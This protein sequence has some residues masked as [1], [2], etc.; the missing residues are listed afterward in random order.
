ME[1]L[2]ETEAIGRVVAA[3]VAGGLLGWERERLQKAAGLRTHALVCEGAALFMVASILLGD[4]VRAAG[5]IGYDPSRI[6]STIVQ[7][8]GFLAAGVIF[9]A[10]GRVRGLTSAATIWVTAAIGLV[11]GAGLYVV[12]TAGVGLTLFTLAGLR[13]IERRFVGRAARLPQRR[14]RRRVRPTPPDRGVPPD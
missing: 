2:S 4:R 11:F 1:R 10:R 14:T 7:G 6:G 9:T 12:G 5:G 3:L 13:W 8:I